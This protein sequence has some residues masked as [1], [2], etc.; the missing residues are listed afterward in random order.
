MA[1]AESTI[2]RLRDTAIQRRHWRRSPACVVMA[3]ACLCDGQLPFTGGEGSRSLSASQWGQS[4][5]RW[6]A[7]LR[8]TQHRSVKW[9]RPYRAAGVVSLCPDR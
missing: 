3:G 8:R 7:V 5:G 4:Q 6:E 2:R 9:W 1:R